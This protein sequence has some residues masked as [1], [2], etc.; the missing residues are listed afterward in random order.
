MP[1]H[2]TIF[3][4]ADYNLSTTLSS[5]QAFRWSTRAGGW[6]GIVHGRWVQLREGPEGIVAQAAT[7]QADWRWLAGFLQVEVDLT[8]ILATFPQDATTT[9]AVTQ[10]RGLRVLRQDP[11]ECLASF[12]LSSTKQIVQIQQ[13]I[14]ALATRWGE[15]VAV[16]PG[17]APAFAFPTAQ[18]L[19]L[20]TE[21][22]LR[23]CKMGFRAPYL[24]EAARAVAS[25]QCDLDRLREM[26]VA[27]AREELL[28]LPGV[29]DKIANCV[30]LFAYGF[31]TAFPVDVW[32][33]KVLRQFY[34][35]R[36]RLSPARFHESAEKHFGP[37]AGYAQQYLF[38]WMRMQKG[39]P[40]RA[41]ER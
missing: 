33:L 15:P 19:A 17:E 11:W 1:G 20:A 21:T 34:F 3:A 9:A 25:G 27:A 26:P 14:A 40:V 30:L 6:I 7:P 38:H 13:I 36:R 5:G 39:L 32:M 8:A 37:N 16:P 28:K 41:V 35:R 12:I 2:E 29:G 22:E 23:A 10:C 24:L 4:V 18:K 31:P